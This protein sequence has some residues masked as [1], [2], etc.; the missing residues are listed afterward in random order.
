[1][2]CP[3]CHLEFGDIY[4]DVEVSERAAHSSKHTY[5]WSLGHKERVVG[6]A[7]AVSASFGCRMNDA[8]AQHVS[9]VTQCTRP[10][11]LLTRSP[12]LHSSNDPLDGII[13]RLKWD[14]HRDKCPLNKLY[15][16]DPQQI[17]PV[18]P[19]GRPKDTLPS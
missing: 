1:M 8:R 9:Q 7:F 4:G 19:A 18:L 14:F 3:V 6:A 15:G 2:V 5:R 16:L 10:I 12:L 17:I 13:L 11:C